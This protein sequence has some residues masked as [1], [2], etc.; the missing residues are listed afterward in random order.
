MKIFNIKTRLFSY[1]NKIYDQRVL[2]RGTSFGVLDK[3]ILEEEEKHKNQFGQD[4]NLIL[5]LNSITNMYF[6]ELMLS[7]ENEPILF[8]YGLFLEE[9][10]GE[11]PKEIQQ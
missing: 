1:N 6:G 8:F 4:S 10:E 9:A 5:V 11:I 7:T 3:F 2:Y